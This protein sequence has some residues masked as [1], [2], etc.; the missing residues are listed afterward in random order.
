[1]AQ[2]P[3]GSAAL[4]RY[5]VR[6]QPVYHERIVLSSVPGPPSRHFIP[7]PDLDLREEPL[8]VGADVAE[9]FPVRA[10]G[11]APLGIAPGRIYGFEALPQQALL[12]AWAAAAAL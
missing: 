4:I 11:E 2:L 3:A 12:D 6:G 7:T 5:R 10:V 9:V 1:M 8:Q